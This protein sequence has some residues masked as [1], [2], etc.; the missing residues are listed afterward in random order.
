MFPNRT[1]EDNEVRGYDREERRRQKLQ[2]RLEQL[3]V[4]ADTTRTRSKDPLNRTQSELKLCCTEK[5]EETSGPGL[6]AWFWSCILRP[7]AFAT[8]P[9]ASSLG[10]HDAF[11][12][13]RWRLTGTI[14]VRASFE[15]E[16]SDG[17]FGGALRL[18]LVAVLEAEL[19]GE[20]AVRVTVRRCRVPEN[21]SS[22]QDK[23]YFEFKAE[24]FEAFEKQLG[25]AAL[26]EEARSA[27][28]T[29]HALDLPLHQGRHDIELVLFR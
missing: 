15:E 29:R 17:A 9:L 27:G 7:F 23:V 11:F 5:E 3:G 25:L 8:M 12:D 16:I 20:D 21:E 13:A 14:T 6:L 10:A 2:L 26:H 22:E 1:M 28:A 18:A 4:P 24:F 19:G